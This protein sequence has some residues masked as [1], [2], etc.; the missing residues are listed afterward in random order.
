MA[1]V[2]SFLAERSGEPESILL[3]TGMTRGTVDSCLRRND[4]FS[5]AF[6]SKSLPPQGQAFR[7]NDEEERRHD[8]R[9]RAY[10][11][12][13]CMCGGASLDTSF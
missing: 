2:P 7:G 8:N 10:L 12:S 13:R 6:A 3:F 5:P 9:E 4:I 11:V 1:L